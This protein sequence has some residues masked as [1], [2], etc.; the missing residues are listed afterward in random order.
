MTPPSAFAPPKGAG[1]AMTSASGLNTRTSPAKRTMTSRT[2]S[3][4]SLK[5]DTKCVYCCV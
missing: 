4:G 2:A 5:R 3:S 1:P